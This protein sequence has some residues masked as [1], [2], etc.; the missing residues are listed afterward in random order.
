M[1]DIFNKATNGFG[2]AFTADGAVF[3]FSGQAG[4]LLGSGMLVQQVNINYQQQV[5]RLWEVGSDLTYYVGGRTQG[6]MTVG[7]V[8]GPGVIMSAFYSRFGDVCNASQNTI[9]LY[10]GTGCYT[11][12]KF[13]NGNFKFSY[14]VLTSVGISVAAQDMVI[15]E[16][17][18]LMFI[19][20][21]NND[22]TAGANAL[23]GDFGS[24]TGGGGLG[25]FGGTLVA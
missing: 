21:S 9:M 8:V 25:G 12:D 5:T 10:I 20:M 18:Q 6:N 15:N 17:L 1:P 11:T 4:N 19:Q 14:C 23:V 3:T 13:K 2:K 24:N 16:N 7:R 22:G